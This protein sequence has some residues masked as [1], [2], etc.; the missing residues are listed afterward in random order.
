[1][2]NILNSIITGKPGLLL[3]ASLAGAIALTGCV[4]LPAPSPIVVPSPTF[5][6]IPTLEPTP[7]TVPTPTTI[8]LNA[9]STL[10][11]AVT[12][13]QGMFDSALMSRNIELY[14][15]NNVATLV[16]RFETQNND[17]LLQFYATDSVGNA[18]ALDAVSFLVEDRAPFIPVLLPIGAYTM[19]V[20][21]GDE[22]VGIGSFVVQDETAIEAK[23]RR[24]KELVE[25][26]NAMTALFME[27]V[28][29]YFDSSVA[30]GQAKV[31][32][33]QLL[34]V[35]NAVTVVNVDTNE[36]NTDAYQRLLS[37]LV[38]HFDLSV[39]H[40]D[41]HGFVFGVNVTA[42]EDKVVNAVAEETKRAVAAMNV[43]LRSDDSATP[44]VDDTLWMLNMYREHRI[45]NIQE[46]QKNNG[47]TIR[48]GMSDPTSFNS[49]FDMVVLLNYISTPKDT[50]ITEKVWTENDSFNLS[51]KSQSPYTPALDRQELLRTDK[52]ARTTAIAIA[53]I[54]GLHALPLQGLSAETEARSL[55][56]DIFFDSNSQAFN[57]NC[58][59]F[60]TSL[61][62]T[63]FISDLPY[64]NEI[65]SLID[66]IAQGAPFEEVL[67]ILATYR[68]RFGDIASY[69]GRH[70]DAHPSRTAPELEE[71]ARGNLNHTTL[72]PEFNR[73]QLAEFN[74]LPIHSP[75]ESVVSIDKAMA[76]RALIANLT[77]ETRGFGYAG[78]LSGVREG[79]TLDKAD[80]FSRLK[81]D[82]VTD[83]GPFRFVDNS[84]VPSP[85]E[86]RV[87]V[88]AGGPTF[89][90]TPNY[91]Q[92]ALEEHGIVWQTEQ[93]A[94]EVVVVVGFG[95]NYSTPGPVLFGNAQGYVRGE[96]PL[97]P[98]GATLPEVLSQVRG[99]PYVTDSFPNS[100]DIP[101]PQYPFFDKQ[102]TAR[103]L[104]EGGN[105]YGPY[106][107]KHYIVNVAR[108]DEG[109]NKSPLHA[110]DVAAQLRGPLEKVF[111][112]TESFKA[113]AV[114]SW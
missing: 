98:L 46:I 106:I 99:P 35:S 24:G 59:I 9:F 3:G 1:M 79:N 94:S 29:P 56:P 114:C 8:P 18:Y 82:D 21:R 86:E 53:D 64:I 55:L 83:S 39:Q 68:D 47:E 23:N 107:V 67:N 69:W 28:A 5:E 62:L 22:R 66:R 77:T 74:K 12:V 100:A 26:K 54:L 75:H 38:E 48:Y 95:N 87:L 110:D 51:L 19:S 43:L 108:M 44:S 102:L 42:T 89:R 92:V 88:A 57:F 85:T 4:E 34:E 30:S 37:G 63:P 49:L 101:T 70:I 11:D 41:T 84:G 2:F 7:T 13:W 40:A 31:L 104:D 61:A 71:L 45:D 81:A 105:W 72:H 20:N 25:T 111:D 15:S 97:V 16:R 14:F 33:E 113:S 10:E 80:L 90:V 109:Y 50:E 60:G 58:T 32:K 76:R 112:N 103:I 6:P 93:S 96:P 73:W 17:S 91:R 27:K 36:F 65:G 78:L 52:H